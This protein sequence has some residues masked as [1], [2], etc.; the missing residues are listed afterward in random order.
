MSRPRPNNQS[1]VECSRYGDPLPVPHTIPSRARID[2][3][4]WHLASIGR[5]AFEVVADVP[6]FSDDHRHIRSRAVTLRS[7]GTQAKS[8]RGRILFPAG[9]IEHVTKILKLHGYSVTV[10]PGMQTNFQSHHQHPDK[11]NWKC[12]EFLRRAYRRRHSL[13]VVHNLGDR[14]TTVAALCEQFPQETVLVISTNRNAARRAAQRLSKRTQRKTTWGGRAPRWRYPW[15]HVDSIDAFFGRSFRD[16]SF[17]VFLDAE[18]LV[19]KTCFEQQLYM[20]GSTFMGFLRREP[21]ELNERD[22]VFIEG[23]LGPV[24]YRAQNEYDWTD[25]AVA[26]LPAPAYPATRATDPLAHKRGQIW[27]NYHRNRVIAR[28]ARAFRNLDVREL[29][30]LGL[31][32]AGNW[33]APLFTSRAPTVAIIVESL[34][35]GRELAQLLPDWQLEPALDDSAKANCEVAARCPKGTKHEPRFKGFCRGGNPA[36]KPFRRKITCGGCRID[37]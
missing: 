15:L 25:V 31:G 27:H 23:A 30:R 33:L 6:L 12:P 5:K 22:R 29:A 14:L 13:A 2:L 21:H 3:W 18:S 1:H 19:T 20:F 26:C 35:H 34:E 37:S 16:W 28:T 8:R 4:D 36:A 32:Q 24:I 11:L 10:R 7:V 9:L 17:V